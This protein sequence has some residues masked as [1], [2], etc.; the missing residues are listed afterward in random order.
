MKKKDFSNAQRLQ[1]CL[2]FSDG[3]PVQNL[4]ECTWVETERR[5]V[6]KWSQE[7]LDLKIEPSP[8][9]LPLN[10][11]FNY[12]ARAP[13]DG[14]H[15]LFSDSIPDGFGLRLMNKGL[16]NAGLSLNAINPLHRLAWI[17]QRGVGALTYRP[18]LQDGHVQDLMSV[19]NLAACA[20]QTEI[21]N[22]LDIPKSVIRAGGSALGARPKFWANLSADKKS[23]LLGDSTEAPTGFT[24]CLIKFAPT[25]GDANEPFYEAACLNLAA[26][27]DIESAHADLLIHPNGAA[28]AV[29][30]FDR[31][32]NGRRMAVQ[33]VAAL[34]EENFRNPG[35]DYVHLAKLIGQL[36]DE[37]NVERFFRQACFNV[38]LSMRDDHCKNFALCMERS[39]RWQLS[40]AFDL[41]PSDGMGFSKEHTMTLLGRGS[42]ISRD[43]LMA[44]ALSLH[45][46]SSV[47][48]DGIEKAR[49]ASNAFLSET[50]FLGAKETG[51]RRWAKKLQTIDRDLAITHNHSKTSSRTP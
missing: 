20:T 8:L 46:P 38:A 10:K 40:P 3:Q 9:K 50:L 31:F 26:R 42:H 24:P 21:E 44:F 5:S 37:Q 1:V 45:I 13:F 15:G 33:S 12:A 2:D 4:G 23:V 35:L 17:G 6:F 41:C 25:G 47:A 39:G 7:A 14:I 48:I 43:D 49:S 34:L 22:F 28:L 30:R 16:I 36:S 11:T 29:R 18:I 32:A 19:S 51:A 27:H